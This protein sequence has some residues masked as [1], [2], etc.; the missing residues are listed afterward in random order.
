[1]LRAESDRPTET[2]TGPEHRR[3][4]PEEAEAAATRWSEENAEAIDAYRRRIDERG[5]FGED[6]RRW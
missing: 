3:S 4:H 1:L 2:A 6:L 5:M